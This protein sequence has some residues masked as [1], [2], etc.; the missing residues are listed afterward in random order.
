MANDFNSHTFYNKL[1][2]DRQLV[3]VK[4]TSCGHL[5]P[6][7]RPMC[8]ECH[9]FDMEWHQFSGK[10]TLSTFTCI[11]V[12]PVLMA[13]KGYGRDKPYC[14]GIVTLEEGPRISARIN[15]VDGNNPQDIQTGMEV[16][17]DFDDLDIEFPSLAFKPA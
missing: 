12:V 3:G 11:S 17:L 2:E 1:K 6:E 13:E 8:P 10:A 16:V 14:S 15:G 7:P 9:G 4:C 5:S